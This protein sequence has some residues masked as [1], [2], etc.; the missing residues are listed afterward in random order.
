[1]PVVEVRALPQPD[2]VVERVLAAI[3]GR[4]AAV[5]GEEPHGT[6]ATWEE[7]RARAYAEGDDLADSQPLD[8]HPPLVRVTAL[9]GRSDEQIAAVLEEV[10]AAISEELALEPGN[11]FVVY[12]EVSSGRVYTGGRVLRG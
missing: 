3:T 10:V 7:I 9:E 8:T 12:D 11:V 2:V 1:V 5:L 4:V 6:W